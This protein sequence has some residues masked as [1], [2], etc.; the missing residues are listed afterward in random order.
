MEY[1]LCVEDADAGVE[2]AAEGGGSRAAAAPMRRNTW[3]GARG[4]PGVLSGAY[5]FEVQL[6]GACLLRVG[7][8]SH[9]SS[10]IIGLDPLSFGYGGTAMKSRDRKF[11]KYGEEYHESAGAIVTCLIDRRDPA[12]ETISYLLDGRDLGVAFHLSPEAAGVPLF[13]A[14]CGKEAWSALFRCTDLAFPQDGYAAL[15]EALEAGDA[16]TGPLVLGLCQDDT[17]VGVVAAEDGSEAGCSTPE[18]ARS[19]LGVRGRPGVLR[20]AY[21]FDVVLETPCLLRVGWAGQKAKRA[22]GND[23][24]SFG[25]GGTGKK[26]TGCNF[27]SYGDSYEGKQG[28]VISCLLDRRDPARQTISY[29]LDGRSLGVAFELPEG[30]HDEP[31]FPALCGK[32]E[33]RASVRTADFPFPEQGY[34]PLAEALAVRDAVAGRSPPAPSPPPVGMPVI[35]SLTQ[36]DGLVQSKRKDPRAELKALAEAGAVPVEGIVPGLRVVLKVHSGPWQGWYTCRV[37]DTDPMGCY[38][39]HECDDFTENVPWAF[40]NAG[41]YSM[42]LLAEESPGEEKTVQLQ[43]QGWAAK[44]QEEPRRKPV[45]GILRR[46]RLRVHADLGAGATLVMC[47][48]GYFASRI[49]EPGQP[50]LRRGDAIVAIGNTMLLGLEDE[51]LEA[52]F[53]EG[54]RDGAVIV[55]GSYL[56]VRQ[57]PF[58]E[59]RGEA[60]QLLQ[61]P[62]TPMTALA[63]ADVPAGGCGLLRSITCA[64]PAHGWGPLR[65]GKLLL[66]PV[67]GQA[68]LDL[69]AGQAGYLVE[70]VL[71][72]PGQPDL[73]PG[74]TIV[75]MGGTLL[76]GFEPEELEERFGE[77]YADGAAF[78]TG[79][80]AELLE[81]PFELVRREAERLLFAATPVRTKTC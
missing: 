30:L 76:L 44:L 12:Q 33:W 34:R 48:V 49:D 14:V 71:P 27:S 72:R 8:A 35:R 23:A 66:D 81:W 75:A 37:M 80:L 62:A 78:V 74:D 65:R 63:R 21:Q 26:S 25:F 56:E 58:S 29:C 7:W 68:G 39:K 24:Q 16:V 70:A 59:V 47:H 54:F 45:A 1:G 52:R 36:A 64:K 20:G 4:R 22:I 11:S 6:E 51:E 73:R 28:A 13:P 17:D 60:E 46:G 42:E 38:L 41:K 31:L 10:R 9:G 32:G 67:T 19:W 50:D 57:R 55:V 69:A 15:A 53:T 61:R 40:L 3:L 79:P 2:V 18:S 77:A 5:Q 43:D